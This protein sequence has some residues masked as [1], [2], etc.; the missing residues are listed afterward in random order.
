MKIELTL[1]NHTSKYVRLVTREQTGFYG[2]FP[3]DH[4]KVLTTTDKNKAL[5]VSIDSAF[6]IIPLIMDSFE[7]ILNADNVNLL[8]IKLVK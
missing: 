7:R 1:N 2:I 6:E 5:D 4:F 8:N 3:G